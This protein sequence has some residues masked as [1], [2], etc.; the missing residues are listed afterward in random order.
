[1]RTLRFVDRHLSTLQ[2]SAT[3]V[4]AAAIALLGLV[5]SREGA[6]V[7]DN[8]ASVIGSAFA[9]VVAATGLI[10]SVY[11]RRALLHHPPSGDQLRTTRDRLAGTLLTEYSKELANRSLGDPD[12]MPV[13]WHSDDTRIMDHPEVLGPSAATFH[14]QADQAKDFVEEFR[15]L[16]RARL[17]VV[18]G[19]GTGKTSLALLMANEMLRGRGETDP[20]PVLV[21]VSEWNTD[22]HPAL[23][24]WLTSYLHRV[25]GNVD[26]WGPKVY[27]KLIIDGQVLP[28]LDGLDEV[29]ETR[30]EAI[31]NAVNA[32]ITAVPGLIATSRRSE[33]V[34]TTT[35]TDLVLKATVVIK[36][37]ALTKGEAGE[38]LRRYLP[39]QPG[40]EWDRVLT[41]LRSGAA[42]ELSRVASNPLGLWLIRTVYVDNRA[43]SPAALIEPDHPRRAGTDS[44]RAHLFQQLIPSVVDARRAARRT[45]A[46]AISGL[47]RVAGDHSAAKVEHWLTVM[48]RHLQRQA[49]VNWSWWRSTE[50]VRPTPLGRLVYRLQVPVLCGVVFACL[51]ALARLAPRAV[52]PVVFEVFV[53]ASV[54]LGIISAGALC[55][56]FSALP[57]HMGFMIPRDRRKSVARMLVLPVVVAVL[58]FRPEV[59]DLLGLD[60]VVMTYSDRVALASISLAFGIALLLSTTVFTSTQ[61]ATAA[62]TPRASHRGDLLR[63]T[64]ILVMITVAFFAV[65]LGLS[66]TGSMTPGGADDD[67]FWQLLPVQQSF[68]ALVLGVCIT[69]PLTA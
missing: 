2:V 6:S 44:L 11:R 62:A 19:P 63:A 23:L 54:V 43:M 1:M 41:R 45:G 18:G 50:Y 24:G 47:P 34:A 27:E 65:E 59:G 9:L 25:Y 28:I 52:S 40:A 31:I 56:R 5:L 66:S 15:H 61:A 38:Y 14:G 49:T 12:A 32:S 51:V 29:T 68:A 20:V 36:P 69:S 55:V 35:R 64:T 67:P 13:R 42:D 37:Y 3:L 10:G 7:A 17:L 26:G 30:R 39:Q 33:Y 58:W 21:T 22:D 4:I 57:A 16:P 60:P 46:V 48:A 53:V 8:W